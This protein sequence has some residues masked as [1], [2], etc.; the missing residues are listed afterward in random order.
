MKGYPS[1]LA[2]SG[3]GPAPHAELEE[4]E[5]YVMGILGEAEK[6]R[7][8]AHVGICP[9][10]AA[11]LAAEA[12]REML[13]LRAW[14]HLV[15]PRPW[16][17]RALAWLAT[18]SGYRLGAWRVRATLALRCLEAASTAVPLAA[19]AVLGLAL[20]SAEF[21][22]HGTGGPL[23]QERYVGL[24][25]TALSELL[26]A[27]AGADGLGPESG[28]PVLACL[29]FDE[30]A[31]CAAGALEIDPIGGFESAACWPERGVGARSC[32]IQSRGP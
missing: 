2:G 20:S 4:L 16:P 22:P 12:G 30:G 29:A 8:E 18:W 7:L 23:R 11:A 17:R 10:C 21:S 19:L 25:S 5:A 6:Q 32:A 13:L 9:R 28:H 31:I 24:G 14:Q 26:A 27:R 3:Q 1:P 15:R